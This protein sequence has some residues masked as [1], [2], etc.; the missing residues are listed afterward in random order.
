MDDRWFRLGDHGRYPAQTIS[1]SST[2]CM[3]MSKPLKI[4]T[5]AFVLLCGLCTALYYPVQRDDNQTRLE[6][7]RLRSI[8]VVG[9]NLNYAEQIL[10]DAGFRLEYT[11]L[12]K[13]TVNQDCL[14]QLVLVGPKKPNF[15]ETIAYT[16]QISWMPFT[17]SESPYVIINA[18]LD[19]KITEIR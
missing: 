14:Q 15:F 12:I 5:L 3:T 16:T 10:M 17:H 6:K 8:V 7:Q 13:P 19:G 2:H 4:F 18:S 9:Q 11:K 1:S